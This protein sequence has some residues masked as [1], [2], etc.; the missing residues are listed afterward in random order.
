MGLE[1]RLRKLEDATRRRP[2]R[3]E[4]MPTNCGESWEM[5][6]EW[7]AL[8]L[9]R[10]LEPDFTMDQSGAFV[11]L[12]GCFAVSRKRMDLRGLMGP[13]TVELQ[14]AI[15]TTPERWKRFL[16]TDEEAAELL[17]RLLGLREAAVVPEDYETPLRNEWTQE[18]ADNFKGAMKPTAIFE[19]AG[20]REAVRRLTWTLIHNPDAT[21][22]F[23][24]LTQ[25]RDAFVADEGSM[26][27]HLAP[28]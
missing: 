8:R 7:T 23:S 20:E 16:E 17:K 5:E 24:E 1:N 13:R 26:P 11:T 22:M 12:D 10:G 14:E 9:I 25:R 2:D 19:D 4:T 15:A 18:E 27:T 21:A 28:C 6:V 3:E